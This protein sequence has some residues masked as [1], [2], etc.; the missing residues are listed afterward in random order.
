MRALFAIAS[1][2]ARQ[3][4]RLLSTWVYFFVFL[5]LAAL[6]VAAAGGAFREFS[7]TFGA[8]V[9]INAPR[10]VA[11]SAAVLGSI[12]VVVAAAVMGRSVQQDFEY[13]THHFFFSAPIPK[14][15]YVFGRFLGALA[16]LAVVFASMV[17]GQ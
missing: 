17:L 5:A 10:Q 8:R 13:E 11:L 16:T 6:W 15:A 4:L 2:E 12:G 9:L 14:T 3:R 7:V 1:F